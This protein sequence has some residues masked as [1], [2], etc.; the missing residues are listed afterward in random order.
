MT[1]ATSNRTALRYVPEVT[2][3]TTPATPAFNELRYTGESLNYNIQNV[4]SNEIRS[5]RMTSDLIQVGADVGGDFNFELSQIAF[6][7]LFEMALCGT[8]GAPTLG[9]SV[10]KNGTTLRSATFQKIFNDATAINYL[11]MHGCRIGG[12]DLDFATAQIL[13]GKFSVMGLGAAIGT[14]QITGATS[15]AAPTK[16]VLNAVSNL[17][18]ITEDG[19]TSTSF[20][21]KLTISLNNNLRVQKAIGSLP[22]IG[23]ALGKIDLTGTIEAYFE[24]AT[25]YN[26]FIN[27]TSFALG[28]TLED[29]DPNQFIIT[30][31]KA[32][33]E[34]GTVVS[35][36]LDQD[37]MFSGTWRAIMDP[38]TSCMIQMERDA[39]PLG[40]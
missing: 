4:V 8:W 3:G 7:S 5:D 21:N 6:E 28:L 37:I 24:N 14:T 19:I 20:F 27:A 10:L 26:K 29:S 35:G 32:K 16:D 31:P 34:S 23:I 2:F 30:I 12:F 36:G 40:S 11:T 38:A 18:S 9:V 22:A 15:N 1:I 13:T 25:L 33:F 17:I 39:F